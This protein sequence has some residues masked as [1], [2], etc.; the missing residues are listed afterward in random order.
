MHKDAYYFLPRLSQLEGQKRQDIMIICIQQ[1]KQK[2]TV[3]CYC[4]TLQILVLPKSTLHLQRIFRQ[5]HP[6]EVLARVYALKNETAQCLC[7]GKSEDF[8]P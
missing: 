5:Q 1:T 8:L 7:Q 6:L 3:N 2:N 4:Y